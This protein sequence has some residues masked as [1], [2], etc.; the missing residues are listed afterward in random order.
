M[1]ENNVSVAGMGVD[2]AGNGVV[3]ASNALGSSF[4][5][6]GADDSGNAGLIVSGSAESGTGAV[7]L[8]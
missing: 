3:A 4:T 7:I 2:Q 1:I 8:A 5:L 6:L